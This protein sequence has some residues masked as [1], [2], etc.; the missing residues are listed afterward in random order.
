MPTDR[1]LSDE[2]KLLIGAYFTHEYSLE[3]A[4]LFN[5]SIVPHPDQTGPAGRNDALH[6]QPARDGRG[7]YFLDHVSHRHHRR[8]GKITVDTPTRFVTTPDHIPPVSYDKAIF[9]RKLHELGLADTIAE[10][11]SSKPLTTISPW[12]N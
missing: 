7:P 1:P 10:T 2:R 3:A 4:A 5:P 8:P 9:W 11:N 12:N 6:S